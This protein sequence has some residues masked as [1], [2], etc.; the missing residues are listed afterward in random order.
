[1]RVFIVFSIALFI[2]SIGVAQSYTDLLTTAKEQYAKKQYK[3]A[4]KTL[5]TA[6]E[7][8]SPRTDELNLAV[9]A[10]AQA[11]QAKHA[12][13]IIEIG[14]NSG[15]LTLNDLLG[16]STLEPLYEEAGWDEQAQRLA[17]YSTG[18]DQ[19]LR[20]ELAKIAERDQY[21]RLQMS[22]VAMDQGWESPVIREMFDLQQ[23]LDSLNF[24]RIEEIIEKHGYPGRSL[25]GP[26][27]NVAFLVTQ[28]AS[29]AKQIEYLPLLQA[30]ADKGELYWA[31]L[32]TLVDRTR[33]AQELPQ[34]YG[35]QVIR[36]SEG[37]P[38]FYAIEN[39]QEVNERRRKVHLMPM[40]EYADKFGMK[41]E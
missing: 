22:D 36:T 10:W 29:I 8:R 11:G 16:N 32:A 19:E 37:L 33:M 5:N 6:F 27:G 2:S 15:W 17:R 20:Q 1:M 26:Q 31:D 12:I 9:S 24:I 35:T 41:W 4:G 21:Y 25:V 30:A 7:M 14:V 28:R 23:E 18:T 13:R 3:R 38:A 39:P 34:I 40:E